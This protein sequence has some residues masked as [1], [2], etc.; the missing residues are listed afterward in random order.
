[1]NLLPQV[2]NLEIT[3]KKVEIK[4]IKPFEGAI[5]Y[6]LYKQISALPISQDGLELSLEIL[7][8]TTEGYQLKITQ[9]K[10]MIVADSTAGAFYA[11][12]TLKQC[13]KN[14]NLQTLTI[15]DY[16]D[17]SYRGV[18]HDVTRGKVP[19]VDTL[20]NFIDTLAYYKINSL[21]LY[22]EHTYEFE[23][24]K[25]IKEEKGYL[26]ALEL[27]E[28]D[29]YCKDNFIE[30]IPSI[31]TFGHM[32]EILQTPQFQHLRVLK[33][34]KLGA[35]E[36]KERMQHHTIDPTNPQ[37]IEVVKSLVDQYYPNFTSE[38][39]NICGDETFDLHGYVDKDGNAV[40][41]KDLYVPFINKIIEHVKSR[42]KRVMMWADILLKYPE[43]INLVPSD[44]MFLNWEYAPNPNELKVKTFKEFNRDQIVCPGTWSWNRLIENFDDGESNIKT[45]IEYGYKYGAKGVLNTN[46]GDWGNPCSIELALYG[47]T[48]GA[49]KSWSATTENNQDYYDRVNSV[50][51]GSENAVSY[52]KRVSKLNGIADWVCFCEAYSNVK[53]NNGQKI[54]TV[55][56]EQLEQVQK[57]YLELNEQ[58]QGDLALRNDVKNEL[59]IALEGICVI[60]ELSA[61]LGK[62]DLE[63]L[64][65]TNSWLDKYK[66]AWLNKNKP[67]ELCRIVKM[68]EYVEAL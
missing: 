63:R 36:W 56:K 50:V 66:K 35:N 22:V 52:I 38:F 32:F 16:P 24:V 26:T 37:S 47:L 33:D 43:T 2:K 41:E 55:S 31:A 6:R 46:W 49:E 68:F 19:T 62:I 9:D 1:M 20:K 67:S 11:L 54:Y 60:A 40:N 61:K 28:I 57:E 42:G 27:Q 13:F 14:E 53:A 8:K 25:D 48:L 39:F 12:Q 44:T 21:Q 34:Y 15:T 65:D 3:G 10:V 64:T 23:Q 51:Y 4:A 18:Y 5:D 7:D 58:I 59:L 17:F 29:Q 30:F 45:L